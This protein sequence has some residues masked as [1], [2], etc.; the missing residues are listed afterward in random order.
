M[1]DTGPA[2]KDLGAKTVA[3][4]RSESGPRSPSKSATE[5]LGRGAND[6]QRPTAG[7][8]WPWL[9]RDPGGPGAGQPPS[10]VGPQPQGKGWPE[11]P[12]HSPLREGAT[13]GQ[14]GSSLR[15]KGPSWTQTVLGANLSSFAC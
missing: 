1:P 4:R 11:H 2:G 8:L 5:A 10:V 9:R 3:Q 14:E 7:R 13:E 15:G 6:L 12:V